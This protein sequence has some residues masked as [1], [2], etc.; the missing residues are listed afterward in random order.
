MCGF[1]G[2]TLNEPKLPLLNEISFNNSRLNNRGPDGYHFFCS[3]C[4]RNY[5]I[6]YRLAVN[7]LTS[8]GTQPFA[9]N[10]FPGKTL[11]FNGEVYNF[12][13]L[14]KELDPKIILYSSSDTEVLYRGICEIGFKFLNRISGPFALSFID[15]TSDTLLLAR[16]R[17]GEKPLYYRF[18]H[19]SIVY[20]SDA[21]QVATYDYGA[22]QVSL[23]ASTSFCLKGYTDKDKSILDNVFSIPPGHILELDINTFRFTLKPY[24]NFQALIDTES[25]AFESLSD[26]CSI[27]DN[28]ST[29]LRSSVERQ[30][31]SDRASCILM[32]GG[33][34]S[35]IIASIASSI[36]SELN[37]YTVRFS[38]IDEGNESFVAREI[39]SYLGTFHHE[40]DLGNFSTSDFDD[41]L[42]NLDTPVSDPSII[43]SS[44]AFKAISP[45]HTVVL[46]GD[47]ADELFAG[48]NHYSRLQLLLK[49]NWALSRIPTV[50]LPIKSRFVSKFPGIGK[51]IGVLGLDLSKFIFNPRQIFQPNQLSRLLQSSPAL[52]DLSLLEFG[53]TSLLRA[54]MLQDV[55]SYLSSVVLPK[56][57]RASMIHG[58]EVRCPFLDLDLSNFS[59]GLPDNLLSNQAERKV[60]L[61][62]LADQLLPSHLRK[63]QGRKYGFSFSV[64]MFFRRSTWSSFLKESVLESGLPIVEDYFINI[65][66]EHLNGSNHGHQLFVLLM[67]SRWSLIH[68]AKFDLAS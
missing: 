18:T 6:H 68:G 64:D 11:V 63:L 13:D 27:V 8:A 65:I 7:D 25:A 57:D 14:I 17:F 62:A 9:T 41:I 53:D 55:E 15:T 10:T 38:D 33:L 40:I 45:S 16:D 49:F 36:S 61:N 24:I 58:V 4:S 19:D 31:N 26:H 23:E 34:D 35:T 20:G 52:D 22:S 56:T 60:L 3:P 29:L 44:L 50:P 21:L 28:V 30:L 51:W 48:Y 1:F 54:A 37:T 32:S 67:L 66:D 59:F 47:G 2:V 43:P 42:R 5:A 46:T 39:A 12:R